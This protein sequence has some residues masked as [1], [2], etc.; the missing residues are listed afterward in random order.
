MKFL[1]HV[2][3]RYVEEL[4]QRDAAQQRPLPGADAR[5]VQQAAGLHLHQFHWLADEAR[6]GRCRWSGT[7]W[8]ANIRLQPQAAGLAHFTR[9]G[10]Y[11][12]DDAGC[13]YAEEWRAVRDR[14]V[15]AD[16]RPLKTPA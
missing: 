13:D 15:A 10:P 1:N 3:T 6:S 4:V 11:F 12:A 14:A 5:Y 7:G 8:S 16:G 2:Q 9:G